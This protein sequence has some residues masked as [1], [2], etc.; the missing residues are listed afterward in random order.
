MAAYLFKDL[1]TKVL[2]QEPIMI[3]GVNV[4]ELLNVSIDIPTYWPYMS[5]PTRRLNLDYIR[6]EFLWYING[7]QFDLSIVKYAK[8]WEDC[9]TD[10]RLYSNYGHYLFRLKGL[11][12]VIG[13]LCED[14]N[15]RQAVCSILN[16]FIH[17]GGRDVPCT[18]AL[19]FVIRQNKLHMTVMMRSNDLWYGFGNDVP[20]FCWIHEIVLYALRTHGY[21]I[22]E[23]G[24]Y[25]HFVNSLHL[26][27]RHWD[28]AMDIVANDEPLQVWAIP[29]LEVADAIQILSSH[30]SSDYT[31]FGQWLNEV[32]L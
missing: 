28:K 31:P 3:R 30:A 20:I 32:M 27:E 26:Y 1:F 23:R 22:L 17:A 12:S 25:T 15:S 19:H 11:M 5:F 24:T 29:A 13:A 21:P 7:D 16:T 10:G 8:Q 6:R 9:I 18:Y 14:R 2:V 4:K